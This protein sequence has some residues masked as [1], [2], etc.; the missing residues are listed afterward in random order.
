LAIG[1]AILG[2]MVVINAIIWPVVYSGQQ[3]QQR[4]KTAIITVKTET[5]TTTDRTVKAVTIA[6]PIKPNTTRPGKCSKT[7]LN[8]Q[9]LY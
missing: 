2:V 8:S 3:G 6:T 4:R 5:T 1:G 7:C 9:T